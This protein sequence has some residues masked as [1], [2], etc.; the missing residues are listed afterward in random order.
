M[1]QV[2][3]KKHPGYGVV[4]PGGGQ[5]GIRVVNTFTDA[6]KR[7]IQPDGSY[8]HTIPAPTIHELYG[9]GFTY[10]DG[11]LVTKREHL[12]SITAQNMRERAL[13]WWD[14]H[15]R[16]I[17][18][19]KD[20]VMREEKSERPEPD[21]ILSTQLPQE[22]DEITKGLNEQ[23]QNSLGAI[24]QSI[25]SLTDLVKKQDDRIAKLEVGPPVAEPKGKG[26]KRQKQGEAMKAK[27]ADPAYREKMLKRIH[28][29]GERN[30][31]NRHENAKKETGG[32][33]QDSER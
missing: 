14:T 2:Q 11:S 17:A 26:I 24:A 16:A 7:I 6:P 18:P 13:T 3:Q 1:P 32:G 4:Y 19:M 20:V 22:E 10:A 21:Y 25:Q 8:A 5:K 31:N 28:G 33:N 27:W 23:M 12:E 9:G 29:K 30:E 15:G